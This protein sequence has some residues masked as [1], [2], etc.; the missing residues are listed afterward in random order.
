MVR[1]QKMVESLYWLLSGRTRLNTEISDRP[2]NTASGLLEVIPTCLLRPADFS[3]LLVD[4]GKCSWAIQQSSPEATAS[5]LLELLARCLRAEEDALALARE[6]V[7]HSSTV[8]SFESPKLAAAWDAFYACL[9]DH[10][11]TD[12]TDFVLDSLA[13]DFQVPRLLDE[14]V[15]SF[16]VSQESALA[17]AQVLACRHLMASTVAE[18]GTMR[19]AIPELN[20]IEVLGKPYSANR[21]AV[22]E[23]IRRHFRINQQS[24]VVPSRTEYALGSFKDHHR[25]IARSTVERALEDMPRGNEPLLVIDDGGALIDA[26]GQEVLAGR[27]HRPVVAIEQTTRGLFAARPFLK[28]RAVRDSGFALVNVGESWAKLNEE[29]GIIA[30]SVLREAREWLWMLDRLDRSSLSIGLIGY[31]AIGANIASQLGSLGGLWGPR[32]D[33]IVYDRNPHKNALA[34]AN[35]FEVGL[36]VEEVV[37]RSGVVI[38]ATGSTSINADVASKLNDGTVLISASSGDSEF[39]GLKDWSLAVEPLLPGKAERTRLSGVHD[40][41]V[42]TSSEGRSVY[43]VNGGFPVNFDGSLD[44]IAPASIQLTRALMLG[45]VLQASGAKGT[46]ATSMVGTTEI[47]DLDMTISQFIVERYQKMTPSG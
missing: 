11:D 14:V 31:G 23:L 45:A 13:A 27:L 3:Q 28:E 18:L 24:R 21:A 40:L 36:T 5:S 7:N 39:R 42:A 22:L 17:G 20:F 32:I 16:K 6:I 12:V 15:D 41:L 38:A 8:A 30:E 46:S 9:E 29:S 44:P 4:N 35:S 47:Y 37:A 26:V 2:D 1:L 19:T 10:H 33:L 34:K 43:I 25:S